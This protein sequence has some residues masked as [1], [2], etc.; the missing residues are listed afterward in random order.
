MYSASFSRLITV[1]LG[2]FGGLAITE[3]G[4]AQTEERDRILVVVQES[5]DFESFLTSLPACDF[6]APHLDGRSVVY[7]CPVSDI[8]EIAYS[9]GRGD[10][11]ET[12][13]G[14]IE[15]IETD[16]AAAQQPF[17]FLQ[18]S[19]TFETIEESWNASLIDRDAIPARRVT[20]EAGSTGGDEIAQGQETGD[21][22]A[23]S[24][25]IGG[26]E[27]G[28]ET[29]NGDGQT[30][31]DEPSEP[32]AQIL[33]VTGARVN[34]R[35]GPSVSTVAI[36]TLVRDDRVEFLGDAGNGWFQIRHIESGAAG[37][38]SG[39]F[40]VPE[41]SH[42]IVGEEEPVVSEET[43][44]PEVELVMAAVVWLPEIGEIVAPNWVEVIAG[45]NIAAL[46]SAQ[47][48]YDPSL[49]PEEGIRLV[50]ERNPDCV[51]TVIPDPVQLPNADFDCSIV[52][53]DSA[54]DFRPVSAGCEGTGPKIECLLAS[55]TTSVVFA[56]P[57]W[58]PVEL[59]IG[60]DEEPGER[61]IAS[62]VGPSVAPDIAL[63]PA[64]V[65]QEGGPECAAFEVETAF[66]GYCASEDPGSCVDPS[67]SGLTT[68][69][70]LPSLQDA[71]WTGEDVPRFIRF[72]VD[73]NGITRLDRVEHLTANGI[74]A[75][76]QEARAF[77]E[78]P[79]LPT[80]L[81]ISDDQYG[82]GRQAV[83]YDNATCSGPPTGE[84]DLSFR[85]LDAPDARICGSVQ[86]QRDG[87][88]I[89]S[90]AP[91]ELSADQRSL[92]AV[93]PEDSC[94]RARIVIVVAQ[95][96]SLSGLASREIA[97]ILATL[98]ENVNAS[99]N[100]MAID[101]ATTQGE[102]RTV[103]AYAEQAFF[104]PTDPVLDEIYAMS[105]VNPRSEIIRDLS[106]IYR[107]WG[108][109][110]AGVILVADGSSVFVA[111]M[112]DA[113]EALAWEVMAIPAVVLDLSGGQ[114]CPMFED[115]L[116]FDS[117]RATSPDRLADDLIGQTV[118]LVPNLR[119]E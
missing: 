84:L 103:L 105:F 89:T 62:A 3:P 78:P 97:D 74:F 37:Y 61:A 82:G 33:L 96:R 73:V 29:G 66:A 60:P 52:T 102:R 30:T 54:P 106:W 77:L 21:P 75:F 41:P 57:T 115:T 83:F 85:G 27:E 117:C 39:D 28:S 88:P 81:T 18:I 47:L 8:F 67:P 45:P 13:F 64:L 35:L 68:M 19:R 55:G 46:R 10:V 69:T 110:M 1:I 36:R 51:A 79:A 114:N 32:A 86:V 20:A 59:T 87:R 34:L 99:E 104:G 15:P 111:D 70:I 65:G 49:M 12:R 80:T 90:C 108:D 44:E 92:A 2:A 98:V 48:T 6:V 9:D 94:A 107:T 24:G 109:R 53:F 95:N 4:I 38:M 100:C 112:I 113:P 91:L 58:G 5:E 71:A 101:I 23:Q 17:P 118:A 14:V 116:F 22:T 72:Q 31:V 7:D 40:L 42:A 50:A 11:V 63:P 43:T 93:L 119:G 25:D 56:S 26:A 76:A 16:L